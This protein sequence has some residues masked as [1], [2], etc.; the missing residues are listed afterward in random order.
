MGGI[1]PSGSIYAH[2]ANEKGGLEAA[3]ST[4]KSLFRQSCAS[5][6]EPDA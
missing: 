1:L 6:L 3:L 2:D 4:W 5:R